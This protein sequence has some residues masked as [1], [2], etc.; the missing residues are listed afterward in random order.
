MCAKEGVVV[1]VGR[2]GVVLEDEVVERVIDPKLQLV[3][4]GQRQ[5]LINCQSV[6]GVVLRSTKHLQN[7]LPRDKVLGLSGRSSVS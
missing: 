2:V 1:E 7:G 6:F 5:D 4:V 3:P